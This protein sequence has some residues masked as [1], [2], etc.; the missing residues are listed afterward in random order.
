MFIDGVERGKQ[1][2]FRGSILLEVYI[3]VPSMEHGNT[4]I[5]IN[6]TAQKEISMREG[7]VLR[8]YDVQMI[9]PV[10][11]LILASSLKKAIP[12]VKVIVK[13]FMVEPYT[14]EILKELLESEKPALV[15]ITCFSTALKD[16]ADICEDIRALNP[17]VHITCGGPHAMLFPAETIGQSWVDSV[18]EG[19]GEEA[20]AALVKGLLAGTSL[21]GI[22][23]LWIKGEG[24]NAIPPVVLRNAFDSTDEADPPD[25]SLVDLTKYYNPFLHNGKGLI[26]VAT[27][28]GCPY[29]CTFCNSSGKVPRLHSPGKIVAEIA[30]NVRRYGIRNVFFIDDTFN[31]SRQRFREIAQGIL[32]SGLDIAWSFRGRVDQLDDET[33]GLA[34]KSGLKHISF[35]IEDVTDEGLKLLRKGIKIDQV[36]NAFSLC[37]KH[38]IKPSANFII[39]LPHNQGIETGEQVLELLRTLKPISVQIS[40]LVIVPGSVIYN[41]AVAKGIVSGNEWREYARDPKKP[42]FYLNW[43]EKSTLKEQMEI[44]KNIYQAFYFSPRYLFRRLSEVRNFSELFTKIKLGARLIRRTTGKGGDYRKLKK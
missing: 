5:L 21:E 6:P 40:I 31:I 20:L 26:P 43:E 23:N 24:G 11:L 35:G 34:K 32:D 7:A 25:L 38:G 19:E 39:G 8:A 36:K 17:S 13:D 28:R 44:T 4:V 16:V 14:R 15:G 2:D 33:L 12:G 10:N 22:P 18:C 41:E 1:D 3:I 27:G 30:A 29:R 9:P 37:H 42:F